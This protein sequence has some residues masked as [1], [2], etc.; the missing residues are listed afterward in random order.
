MADDRVTAN[1]ALFEAGMAVRRQVLGDEH[2][3]R[4]QQRT[5]ELTR[6]F[7]E[8]ITRSAWGQVWA[9]DELDLHTRR[10]LTI[11]LLTALRADDELEM[12]LR[13]ALRADMDP[14]E[15][16]EVILHTGV[17][18]GVPAANSALSLLDRLVENDE[19]PS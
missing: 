9:R 6:P 17:Y 10:Q 18:A 5:T 16:A 3:D 19:P 4:A 14:A 15:L 1:D 13:A 8:Y 7:Q 12:H 11:A 2:V